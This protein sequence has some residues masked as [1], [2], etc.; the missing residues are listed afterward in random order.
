MALC[1]GGLYSRMLTCL[2]TIVQKK[3]GKEM[4]H[5]QLNIPMQKMNLDPYTQ[6]VTKWVL[7]LKIR[8]ETVRLREENME[9]ISVLLG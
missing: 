5:G 9:E 3:E 8:P 7:D 6:K 2:T 4:A 1:F